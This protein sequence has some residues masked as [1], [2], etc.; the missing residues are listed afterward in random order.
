M[1]LN[2]IYLLKSQLI[3]FNFYFTAV[4]RHLPSS[5]ATAI[6][7]RSTPWSLNSSSWT[8]PSPSHSSTARNHRS[9][10]ILQT[11]YKR[12]DTMCTRPI[13]SPTPD[14]T[15][16]P[17]ARKSLP[18]SCKRCSRCAMMELMT[19]SFICKCLIK[20][21]ISPANTFHLTTL[22]RSFSASL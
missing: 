4:S 2:L 15:Y 6:C 1:Q 18:T 13:P 9:L 7:G 3:V 20:Q 5:V 22:L 19:V 11:R 21:H 8:T 17:S 10:A 14:I 16:M 12:A